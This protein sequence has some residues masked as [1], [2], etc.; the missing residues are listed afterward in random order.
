MDSLGRSFLD[1]KEW[2]LFVLGTEYSKELGAVVQRR[3]RADMLVVGSD[4]IGPRSDFAPFAVKRIPYLFFSHGTHK[5]YHGAGDSADRVDYSRLAQDANL[6]EAMAVDIA[7]L[8]TR[9]M[10]LPTPQYPA[11]EIPSLLNV[12]KEIETERT[13]LPRAYALMFADLKSRVSAGPSRDTLRVAASA[14]LA[15]AT[16][17]LSGFLLNLIL[18]PFY[19]NLNKPEIAAA[20]REEASHWQ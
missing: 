13:D 7:Q 15:L 10:Y 8:K 11:N 18:E 6:I 3:G 14:L 19:E 16:P 2:N 5:D 4:L 12:V 9:P 17:R 1:L 20:I